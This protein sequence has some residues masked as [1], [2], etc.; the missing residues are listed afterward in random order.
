[1]PLVTSPDTSRSL[2]NRLQEPGNTEDW[3]TF[4]SIYHPFL[5]RHLLRRKVRS[6]DVEDVTQDILSRVFRSI[7]T[8]S[9]NGRTGA[10]RKWLG[11][12]VSQQVWRY[13]QNLQSEV[14]RSAVSMEHIVDPIAFQA[15]FE[16]QWDLEHDQFCLGRLLELIRPEFTQVTWQAFQLTVLQDRSSTEVSQLLQVTVNAVVISK[17]RVLKRLRTLGKHLIEF[18]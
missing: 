11:Q 3:S 5:Q 12:I 13:F 7:S 14:P 6:V 8:F 1:M 4:F 15:D 10:F 16:A 17:S 2:L 9:H 18:L